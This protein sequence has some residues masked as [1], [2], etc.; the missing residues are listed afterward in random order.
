MRY[1]LLK[2]EPNVWSIEHQKKMGTKGVAWEGVRNYQAANN[3]K[4]MKKG[5]LCFF[6]HS[7]IGKEIV[8]IVKV[9]KKAFLDKTDKKNRFVAVQVRFKK[10]FRKS[11][12]LEKIKKNK[13]I[14][15]LPLIKQSRLSVMPIDFKSWKIINKMGKI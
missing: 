9:T 5:D 7:N 2:S 3:L 10:K 1:W 13:K 12:T 4:K 6:Y 11:I 14:A 15:H 8:G